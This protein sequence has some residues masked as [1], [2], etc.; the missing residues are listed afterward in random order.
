ME[1]GKVFYKGL[2][3]Y[4]R[5]PRDVQ[6]GDIYSVEKALEQRGPTPKGFGVTG[7]DWGMLGNAR[8]GDCFFAAYAHGFMALAKLLGRTP[9]FTEEGILL[10]YAKYLGVRHL[11]AEND[12]GTD[13]N[14]G[15]KF[16][17]ATGEE[18]ADGHW[19]RWGDYAFD[20]DGTDYEKLVNQAFDFGGLNLCLSLQR[21]QEEQ[22]AEAEADKF[23]EK[24]TFKYVA[25]S[26]DVGGH[27]IEVVARD[28]ATGLLIAISWG[29]EVLID[30]SL[31][32]HQLQVAIARMTRADIDAEGKSVISG[33]DWSQL[34][35]NLAEVT[36]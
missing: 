2:N 24:P 18:A 31:P 19:R 26:P 7:L 12:A 1:D 33:L 29:Q 13:P 25:G 34:E 5:D 30:P 20:E 36:A 9:T 15:S 17:S 27:S 10:S 21:A 22:F 32:E 23:A 35:A 16:M 11:T 6:V 8:F 3:D 14:T 4:V 28:E